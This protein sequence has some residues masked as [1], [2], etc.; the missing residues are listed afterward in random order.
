[1][2]CSS[3][4]LPLLYPTATRCPRCGNNLSDGEPINLHPYPKANWRSIRGTIIVVLFALMLFGM[5]YG[6]FTN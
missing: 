2:N 6:Y 3:C 1:M 4:G 5:V